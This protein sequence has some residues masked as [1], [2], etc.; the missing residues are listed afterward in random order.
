MNDGIRR[1]V[2]R[3]VRQVP[4]VA[5][6]MSHACRYVALVLAAMKDS[7]L[8]AKAVQSSDRVRTSESSASKNQNTHREFSSGSEGYCND[9]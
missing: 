5:V 2:K 1:W 4:D 7:D 9:L 3:F 6:Q 8:V